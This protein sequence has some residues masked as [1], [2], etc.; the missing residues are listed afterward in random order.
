MKRISN[1]VASRAGGSIKLNGNIQK[2]LPLSQKKKGQRNGWQRNEDPVLRLYRR[3]AISKKSSM[4][5]LP[6]SLPSTPV[7]RVRKTALNLRLISVSSPSHLR[8][9]FHHSCE[10][11]ET[12]MTK[13]ASNSK[14]PL[15]F[16]RPLDFTKA[17]TLL[18]GSDDKVQ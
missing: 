12:Q 3:P 5:I 15:I 13:R 8:R 10:G 11:R 1:T 9:I 6:M 4:G 14:H 7:C 16:V 2:S 17:G 18:L